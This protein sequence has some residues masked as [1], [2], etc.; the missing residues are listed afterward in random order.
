MAYKITNA[1]ACCGVC[2]EA[3]P[4][5][6]ITKGPDHYEIAADECIDCGSC[7]ADCPLDAIVQE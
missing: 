1:C 5:G 7:A 6:I 3:C 4:L 2:A